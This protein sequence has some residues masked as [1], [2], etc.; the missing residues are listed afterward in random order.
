MGVIQARKYLHSVSKVT[1]VELTTICKGIARE[2][3][4][5]PRVVVDCSNLV[6]VYLNY[7]SPT[8]AVAKH[9]A[10]F[11]A[12]GMIMVPVCDG[13]ERPMSK[14]AT[15]DRIAKKELCRITALCLRNQIRSIKHRIAN[16]S[17]ADKE[18]LLDQVVVM[19]R[20]LKANETQAKQS[21]PRNF[22]QELDHELRQ[23]HAYSVDNESA[24]GYVE[25]VVVSE[26]Q[27]DAFMAGQIINRTAV[28]AMTRD[29]DIPIVA[30]D[31][32]IS[33]KNFTKG[34]YDIVSTSEATLRNGES[35]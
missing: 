14:Q 9:L 23:I 35:L 16:Q 6:F 25:E 4:I 11:S 19:S 33:I 8:D 21:M 29:S 30:G 27:A 10:R 7:I 20:Q 17:G 22:V 12:P 32:C 24:G 28:M 2:L 18:S 31:C 3:G 13:A 34:N 5:A 1:L 26:F 15:N